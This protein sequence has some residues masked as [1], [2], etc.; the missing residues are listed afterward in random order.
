[1]GITSVLFFVTIEKSLVC[2]KYFYNNIIFSPYTSFLINWVR[3]IGHTVVAKKRKE[4]NSEW[5]NLQRKHSSAAV[6][7]R[8]DLITVV[9][10]DPVF[11]IL[12][13]PEPV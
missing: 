7:S 1:M 5:I 6:M 3:T 10:P 9:D 4:N 8:Y 13:D 12:S 2:I 11:R